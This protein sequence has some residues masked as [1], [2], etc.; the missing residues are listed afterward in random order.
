VALHN[1]HMHPLDPERDR[2]VT[3]KMT[4]GP[5][6]DVAGNMIKI[7]NRE[8][9]DKISIVAL[10]DQ[11]GSAE[12]PEG[13]QIN[14]LLRLVHEEKPISEFDQSQLSS[15]GTVHLVSTEDGLRARN[16]MH[17]RVVADAFIPAGGRPSTINEDNWRSF[18][19][20]SG[21]PSAKLIVEGANLFVTPGARHL[22]FNHCKLPIVKDSSAN[23]CGVICSSYEIM[24]SMLLSE[25]EF[26]DH[27]EA[28]VKDVLE[29]LRQLARRE[30]ELLFSEF[31]RLPGALP[32]FS[33]RISN[34]INSA[35][36]AIAESLT[37]VPR[38]LSDDR[39]GKILRSLLHEHLPAKLDE[40]AGVRVS[41]QAPAEYV[42]YAIASSL[43]SRIVYNEGTSLFENL[44]RP[45][46]AKLALDYLDAETKV[47]DILR[48][49]NEMEWDES[50]TAVRDEA[51]RMIK[52]GGI[53][54]HLSAQNQK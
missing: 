37:Q 51:M 52:L 34:T 49:M 30:A 41:R 39:H 13:L 18:L 35:T 10:C 22:L 46:L 43:A 32:H 53:R 28:I 17:N 45:R 29:R 1:L 8:Y 25:S 15:R 42:K 44:D 26:S 11:S 54:A 6:G 33:E 36:D 7:L 3:I 12:D 38:H 4:G 21:E 40:L 31:H 23:K 2:P 20:P 47:D 9:G 14:E 48:A 50:D 19:L 24:S 16:T 5:D 27:K